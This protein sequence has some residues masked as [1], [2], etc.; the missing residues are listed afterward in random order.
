[1]LLSLICSEGGAVDRGGEDVG[2]GECWDDGARLGVVGLGFIC[3][4][5]NIC[6]SFS[7]IWFELIIMSYHQTIFF[8]RSMHA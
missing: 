6:R 5:P 1:M 7:W 2:A 4:S 8:H 3:I